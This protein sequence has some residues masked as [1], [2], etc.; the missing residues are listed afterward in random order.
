MQRDNMAT[1]NTP[2][3]MT[4]L[5]DLLSDNYAPIQTNILNHLGSHSIA[6]LART[7]KVLDLRPLLSRTSYDVNKYLKCFFLDLLAF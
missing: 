2:T 5:I 7:C 4:T 6:K 1:Q 3:T